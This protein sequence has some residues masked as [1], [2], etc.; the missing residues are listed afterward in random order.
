[1]SKPGTKV[2]HVLRGKISASLT[3]SRACHYEHADT[4]VR[5]FEG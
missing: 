4:L 5:A 2:I 3:P 1:M